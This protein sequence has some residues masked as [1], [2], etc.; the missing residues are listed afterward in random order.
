MYEYFL[1]FNWGVN[2]LNVFMLVAW[3]T[4]DVN[5]VHVNYYNLDVLGF[6]LPY[7]T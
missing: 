6:S 3:F 5:H 2:Y 7:R 4:W 1:M